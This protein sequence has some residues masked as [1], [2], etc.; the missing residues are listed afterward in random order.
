MSTC[1]CAYAIIISIDATPRFSRLLLA[2]RDGRH[3]SQHFT[4]CHARVPLL[5]TLPPLLLLP[6]L[7]PLPP[8]AAIRHVAAMPFLLIL[9][10]LRCRYA[11]MPPRLYDAYAAATLITKMM[12]RDATPL[13]ERRDYAATTYAAILLCP[14][15]MHASH[16]LSPPRR[17][18]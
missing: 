5:F 15:M 9:M 17:F 4:N 13:M 14:P 10:P 12:P 1:H 8:H 7:M 2:L 11:M 18:S 16:T 6:P 3:G